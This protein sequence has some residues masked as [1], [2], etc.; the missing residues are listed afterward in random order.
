MIAFG[1][2]MHLKFPRLALFLKH[3]P[4]LRNV[5]RLGSQGVWNSAEYIFFPLLMLA[6]TPVFLHSLG[7]SQYGQWMMLITLGSLGGFAGMGMGAATIREVASAHAEGDQHR[8][9]DYIRVASFIVLLGTAVVGLLLVSTFMLGGI[10]VFARMGD[11]SQ[12]IPIIIGAPFLIASDQVDSVFS[13][14]LRGAE[15]FGLVARLEMLS[16]IIIVGG[17]LLTA[18]FSHRLDL[19]IIVS[20]VLNFVRVAIKSSAVVLIF[21]FKS[22]FPAWQAKIA[23]SLVK[24]GKWSLIQLIGS[25]IFSTVDKLMV[26]S[27]LGANV[28]ASYSVCLQLTQQVQ[29]IPAAFGGFLFPYFT[30]RSQFLGSR[31]QSRLLIASTA[32]LSLLAVSIALPI[33]I[34]AYPLLSLWIGSS[35]AADSSTLIKALVLGYFILALSTA[36]HYFLYGVGKAKWVA[37]SNLAAGVLTLLL[38]FILVPRFGVLGAALTRLAYGSLIMLSFSW[39]LLR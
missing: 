16:K 5:L 2:P 15:R 25:A 7:A 14:A 24:F 33:L 8:A 37:L 39:K 29:S 13:G 27:V 35:F 34:L 23:T 19:L 18:V 20:V 32:A 11:K 12:L 36:A 30:K 3:S 21:G 6:A 31:Q 4:R 1:C 28:L 38:S 26:G 22:I 9:S 17:C 10:E